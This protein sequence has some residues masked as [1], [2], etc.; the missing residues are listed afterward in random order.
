KP[1][2]TVR[3]DPQRSVY[4]GDTVTLTCEVGQSAGWSFVWYKGSPPS[5]YTA[6]KDTNTIS[7]TESD[8]GTAEFTCKAHRQEY[9]TETSD[10]VRITVTARPKTTVR[11]HP[12]VHVF[13][14]ETA[15]LTCD[16]EGGGVWQYQ[17][18]KDNNPLSAA[19][20][21][22]KYIISKTDQSHSGVYTCRGTQSTERCCYSQTSEAVRLTVSVKPKPTVAAT[23]P[24]SVYT[25]DTVTLT[26]KVGQSTGWSF[27]WYKDSQSLQSQYPADKDPNTI[28]VTVSDVGTAGFTCEAHRGTYSTERSAPAKITVTERPKPTVK[29]QPA[30]HVFIGE[31]VTLTCDIE[32]GGGWQYQW[33]KDN[34]LSDAQW[35]KEYN[36]FTADQSHSGFYTCKGTKSTEKCCY[37]QTSEAVRLTVSEKPKPTVRVYPQSSVYPGDTVTLTCKVGQSTGWRFVW[38]KG[39]QSLQS[40]YPA[41]RDPNTISVTVSDEGTAG[42][43]CEAHRGEYYTQRS[44]PVRITVTARPKATVRV[45]PA[46]HVLTGET[47]TLTCGIENGGDWRYQWYKDNT[48]LKPAQTGNTYTIDKA[49]QSDKGVYTCRGTRSTETCCYSQTS[50]AVTLTVS[51]WPTVTVRVTSQ[52]SVYTGDTVTLTCEVRQS[53]GWRFLWYKDS[54]T[55]SQSQYT[56][57]KNPNTISV[58]MSEVGTPEFTCAARRKEYFTYH[59]Y[60]SSYRSS[61]TPYYY[62]T[63]NS[64]PAVITVKERPKSTVRVQ[65]AVHVFIGE[66]VTL[67]CDIKGG[68]DWQ[69]QWS[70]GNKAL[71]KAQWKKEYNTFTADWSHSATYSCKGTQSTEPSYSQTSE[72][73]RLTVSEKPKPTVAATSPT[74]VYSGDTVTLTCEVGQSTGWRFVWYKGSQSL[75]SQYPADKDPNTISVTV[76]DVGTAEF[77][78]AAHRGTYSTQR[79]DPVRITVT[80][81]PKATVRVQPAV[82]VLTGERVTL[83]CGIESGGDWRYQWFKDKALKP[84]QTG[85]TYTI[86]K[87]DQSDK[88]VYTCRGTQSTETCCYS[89]TSDGVTLTVSAERPK[90]ELTSSHK[91]AA[92][93]GN[94][95]VLYCKLDPSAGWKFYWSKHT[96]NP[97]NETKT[98][99][100][101]YIISSVSVSDGGEYWCRAG[102]G[103][104]VY[105]TNHSDAL[106]INTTGASPPVSLMVNPSRTQHFTSDSLSLSCKGEIN[107]TGW[108]VR[109]YTDSEKESDCSSGWGSVTGPTYNISSLNTSHTGVYWCESESGESSNPVNITVHNGS[110]ILESPVDPVPEGGPLTLHCL[111]RHTKPSNLTAEFYKNGSLLQTQTTGEMTI[112]TVS[113]SDKGLYHCKH[114]ERGESPQSWISVRGNKS[115]GLIIIGVAAALSVTL[116]LIVILSL[117]YCYKKKKGNQKNTN[118]TSGWNQNTGSSLL[119]PGHDHVYDSVDTVDNT[120]T[121]D[122]AAGSSD[123]TYAQV[124]FGKKK[125]RGNDNPAAGSND[126]TYAQVMSTKK[127]PGQGDNPPAGSSDATYAQ[128]SSPKKKPG[129]GD[130]PSAGS[131]DAAYAQ[132]TSPKKKPGQGDNPS[133]G[134]SDAAYAQVTS[135]KK[136]PGQDNPAAGSSDAAYAQVSSPKKKPGQGDNP[137]AGS[138]DTAY[139]QV[140]STKKKL[141]RDDDSAAGSSDATYAQPPVSK[142]VSVLGD[143]VTRPN[144]V[145]YSQIQ[146]NNLKSHSEGNYTTSY[147]GMPTDRPIGGIELLH[148]CHHIIQVPS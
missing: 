36:T 133:S 88:G 110:V 106:W 20:G 17:W 81:R 126:V 63:Q 136:K 130:H 116:F 86:D 145:T 7:V 46:V 53:A 67:T 124:L 76:S 41:D 19:R 47:V 101:S 79:S 62:Y 98:E 12:A 33:S 142:L 117:I 132:V 59:R 50:E 111:Y 73:V 39:S 16:I 119:Q 24:T 28:S 89:Q 100:P 69:Y 66:T 94:P 60:R 29:V 140:T 37:S 6:D 58:T 82:H 112:P 90:P 22:K 51:D 21:K 27:V 43:T 14:G 84:A 31:T 85:N 32:G 127:K 96:Q 83:T 121:D 115:N 48:A 49:D 122:S 70:K 123:I 1:K 138:S 118:Q 74:S 40:Q 103:D 78:C 107:S 135:P 114:P 134:S 8:A 137:S 25:G 148:V 75:Q 55:L 68:G 93:I 99:T 57:D 65:P 104:P 72:A 30:D 35:K 13:I 5:Q 128:V 92:L 139:A 108:R 77:T 141:G 125:L 23:S 2:P 113:K 44:D 120:N 109:R 61:Y 97:E 9:F 56:A 71:S 11:V 4:T 54:I 105:Y 144:D 18:Y 34:P 45:Q 87:V 95:V 10:P 147:T 42:F 15:T 146:M 26:C 52:S 143:A 91:G 129:Q 131:S 80:A 38:Y 64:G 3:V 102:R